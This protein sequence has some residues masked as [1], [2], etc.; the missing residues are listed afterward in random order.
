MYS[1]LRILSAGAV[2]AL[3]AIAP[4]VAAFESFA[5][6]L[7]LSHYA[8]GLAYS[9]A[10]LRALAGERARWPWLALLALATLLVWDTRLPLP[11]YFG[12]HHVLNEVYMLDRVTRARGDPRVRALRAAGLVLHALLYVSLL[13]ASRAFSMLPL[14]GLLVALGLAVLGYLALLWRARPVLSRA[15]LVDHC[16]VELAALPLLALALRYDVRVSVL[17]V[18]TYHFVFWML[19]PALA[20]RGA[21]GGAL[22]RYLLAS[23]VLT[24]ACVLFSPLAL[25]EPH[26]GADTYAWLFLLFSYVHITLSFALSDANPRWLRALFHGRP[27]RA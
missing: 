26:F 3:V 15:E 2:A 22:A 24:G 19:Y 5:W 7:A 23:L 14:A 13:H 4:D 21:Q 10:P 17:E 12:V 20:R 9:H 11:Y 18:A 6:S 1:L 16:A 25:V 27:A 8:L